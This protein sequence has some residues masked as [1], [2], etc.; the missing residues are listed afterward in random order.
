VVL[1]MSLYAMAEMV[2]RCVLLL[3][4]RPRIGRLLPTLAG[5]SR[6]LTP[7]IAGP[8]RRPSGEPPP[9]CHGWNIWQTDCDRMTSCHTVGRGLP[10]STELARLG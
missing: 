10:S 9:R 3:T 1:P 5:M 6:I 8:G 2:H 4:F 7:V